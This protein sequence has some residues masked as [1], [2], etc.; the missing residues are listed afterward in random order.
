MV[1]MIAKATHIKPG[2]RVRVPMFGDLIAARVIK[3]D[4]HSH[5][6]DGEKNVRPAVHFQLETH[7]PSGRGDKVF[8]CT[9]FPDDDIEVDR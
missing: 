8:S 3:I 4:P 9:F 5:K 1:W 6:L 7:N 2:D